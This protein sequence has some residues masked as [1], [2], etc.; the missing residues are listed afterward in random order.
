[1][2]NQLNKSI[3]ILLLAILFFS[4]ISFAQAPNFNW[5][6]RAGGTDN[7]YAAS[8]TSDASGNVYVT[9]YYANTTIT[10]GTITLTRTSNSSDGFLVKYNSSGVVQ[11]AI[12]MGSTF[13][14]I[15]YDVVTD[16]SGNIFVTGTFSSAT[17][18]FGSSTLTNSNPG[19]GYGDI[20][21]AKFDPSN[22]NALWAK[23]ATGVT[24]NKG[25][26]IS[27]S[28]DVD[29]S[30]NVFIT[31][32]FRGA[33]LDFEG[34]ATLYNANS[35]LPNFGQPDIFIAKYA[36]DGTFQW[37]QSAGGTSNDY[38]K[39]VTTDAAG[40]AII[41]G[42][43]NSTDL[44]FDGGFSSISTAGIDDIFVAKYDG[45][46]GNNIWANRYGGSGTDKGIGITTDGNS[47]IYVTGDFTSG[48]FAFGTTNLNLTGNYDLFIAKLN[49]SGTPQWAKSAGTFSGNTY[50]LDVATDPSN[51]VYMAAS[52]TGSSLTVGATTLNNMDNSG[53]FDNATVKYDAAGT[54]L[55]VKGAGGTKNDRVQSITVDATGR[56]SFAGAFDGL[57]SIF[58]TDTLT[59]NTV[60]FDDVFVAQLG[61]NVATCTAPNGTVAFGTFSGVTSS[62]TTTN[63]TYTNGGN[64]A[65]GYV[66]LRNTTNTAP[67]A[68][69]S[70]TAVPTAGNSVTW[71]GT[72]TV[73]NSTT[74]LGSSVPFSSTGLSASTTYYYWVVAYQNTNGPCWF[75][76]AT[77]ANNSQ[78]TSAVTGATALNFDGVDDVVTI[79][80][81]TTFNMSSGT[82]EA[83]FK[84]SNAGSSFRAIV[85]KEFYYGIFLLDNKIYVHNWSG[86][87]SFTSAG[88]YNDNN[89]H[90]VAFVFQNGVTNGSKVF[91][92]GVAQTAFTYNA[93]SGTTTLSIG[94]SPNN[95]QNFN[96]TI[97]EVRI[98][99]TALCDGDIINQRNCQLG[100]TLSSNLLAYYQ[101]NQGTDAG[102]NTAITTL[103][104]SKSTYPGTLSG[105]TLTGSTSNFLSG[106][107][108]PSGVTCTYA[109]L[110]TTASNTGA[111]CSGATISVS[112]SPSGGTPTYTYSW[113]SS[114]GGAW[115]AT[116]S[117]ATR[118][119][120]TTAMSGAYN[121][122]VTDAS[123]CTATASTSV[124]VN[125]NPTASIGVTETSG[126]TNNDGTI[127]NGASATLTATGGGTY[128]W[129]TTATTAAITVN[130]GTTTPYTVT[131]TSSGCTATAS[132][133]ITV[134]ANPSVSIGVTETSGTTNNDGTICNG[135]SATLTAS[136]GGTYLWSTSA[137][138]AAITVNPGTTTPYT[139]TVTSS[140]C[141]ATAGSSITVNANPATPTITANETSGTAN[142]GVIC[143]GAGVTL[144]GPAGATTYAWSNS[145]GSSQTSS[146][147]SPSSNTTYSLAVS[148]ASGCIASNSYTVT[149]TN[150]PTFSFSTST[151]P[152]TCGA[153][154]GTIVLTGLSNSTTYSVTYSKN[155]TPQSAANFTSNGSGQLT[156]TGLGAGN[157][158]NIIVTLGGCSSSAYSGPVVLSDP[159]APAAPTVGSN[160]PVCAGSTINLTATGAGTSF[161]WTGPNTYTSTTQNPTRP[162]STTAMS[163][164]YCATQTLAGCTSAPACVTVTVNAN[165]TASIGVT[166]TSGTANND[167][168]ICNGAS[169]TLTASGGG[170]Y[171]WS[172][173]ATTAAITVNPG[174]TTPYTV[175]VTSS[176]CTATASS[177][178]TVNANPSVSIGVT[179]TSGTTNNDGTICN[180]ASATLTASGGGTYLWSTSATTAA[181]TVNPGTT[182]PYTVTVTSSGCTATAGSSITVN[183]NPSVSIGVTETSGTANNDGTIC[184]GASATLTATG[185]GT[186]LWSTSATTAAI[187][188]NPGTTTPYT[189][190]VTSSGCTA[191]AGS[192]ITVNA[193][194]T[195]PIIG[196]ITQPTCPV[197]TGSVTLNGLPASGSWTVTNQYGAT[198]T[199]S[200][201]NTADFTNLFGGYSYTFTV[202]TSGCTSPSSANAVVNL[203][204]AQPS[205]P[206]IGN[207]THPT[208]ALSTG[209]VELSGLPAAAWTV[210][211]TGGATL[212]GSTAI[213]TFSGLAAGTYT[214]TVQD[215]NGCISPAS[216]PVTI[217]AQPTIP[218]PT[219]T[220]NPTTTALTC[221]TT[222]ID[223]TANGG[224]TYVWSTNATTATISATA[225]GTYTVTATSSNGCT[226][227]ASETITSNTLSAAITGNTGICAGSSTTLSTAQV[228]GYTYNWQNPAIPTGWV[229]VGTPGFSADQASHQ[230]LAID[231][232]GTPYVAY[233]DAANNDKTTVMKFDGTA[234]VTVGNAG[235]SADEASYQSLTIYNNIPYVAYRDYGNN[236]K[237]TVMKFNGTAWVTVGNAGFSAGAASYQSLAIDNTGTP[238]VAYQDMTANYKTTVMKF[239][240]TA[241]VNVG[242]AAFSSPYSDYQSLAIYNGTP[243]V[244]YLNGLQSKT[245]VLKFDGTAWINVGNVDVSLG[246]ADNQSLAIDNTGTP[247]VAYKDWA[248]SNKTT[249][250]KFDGTAWV[251]VGN[252]GFSQGQAF[253]Q[254]LAIDNTGTPY[255]VYKDAAN[256]AKTTVMKFNGTAWVNVGNAGFSAGYSDY[257]SLSIDNTGTLYV[258]YKDGGNGDK[259]TVLKFNTAL[260][261]TNTLVVNTPGTY[262]LT[263][264]DASG[265]TATANAT[266]TQ[267]ANTLSVTASTTLVSTNG[268]SNGAIDLTVNDGTPAYNYIWSPGIATTQDIAN[269]TAGVYNVTVTDAQGCSAT[270]SYPVNTFN[271][272][273]TAAITSVTHVSCNGG[274]NGNATVTATGGTGNYTY[275]WNNGYDGS[276][277]NKTF[278]GNNKLVSSGFYIV[279]V[280]DGN[281]EATASVTINEPPLLDF[282]TTQV[283]ACGA[284]T[285]SI[286]VNATGGTSP[287]QYASDGATFT[288]QNNPYTFSGLT[289]GTYNVMVKDA[290]G[291]TTEKQV[292]VGVVTT[293]VVP[294]N[295]TTA[296]GNDGSITLTVEGGTAPYTY[297]WGDGPTTQNRTDLTAGSYTVTI[298]DAGGCSIIETIFITQPVSTCPAGNTLYVDQSVTTSGNGET[299]ATAYKELSE[300]L[301]KAAACP[302]I[303][304]I[305]VA[306]GTYKPLHK[307][308]LSNGNTITTPDPRDATF[309]ILTNLAVYG[310]HPTGG[311]TRDIAAN[312]TTLSG[313]I[314]NN[315]N[316][317]HVVLITNGTFS[318]QVTI[319]G[320]TITDGKAD[321]GGKIEVSVFN[322][323][324]FSVDQHS[325]G[326]IYTCSGITTISN[327]NITGNTSGSDGGGIYTFI[328]D[329]TISNNII[330]GNSANGGDGGG[331]KCFNSN[332]T[333]SNNTVSG[334][335]AGIDGGGIKCFNSNSTI[336]N[337][338]V[339]GN[340]AVIDGG[341]IETTN[342]SNTLSNNTLSRNEAE[343][344]GG[345]CTDYGNNTLSNNTL[346]RNTAGTD[347]GGI[348]TNGGKNTI[349]NNILWNNNAAGSSSIAEA[350]YGRGNNTT[351]TF[352]NNLLQLQQ[353]E[354]T[355]AN[356]NDLGSGATGNLFAVDPKFVN[357]NDPNVDAGL[358][359]QAGS[360][361]INAGI[362][363][364]GIPA[365]D[366]LG[367]AR[368]GATDIGAYEFTDPCNAPVLYVD[369]TVTTSGNGDSWATA[370]K[371]LSDALKKAHECPNVTQILV[372]KGTY[373]PAF[374]PFENGEE[375]TANT[376]DRDKTFHLRGNLAVYGGYDATTGTR[377]I[378]ANPTILSGDIGTDNNNT[379]NTYHVVLIANANAADI[380]TLD[381]FTISGGNGNGGVTASLTINGQSVNKGYGGGIYT[382]SG[383]NIISNNTISANTVNKKGGGI[384]T[385]SGTNTISNNTFSNNTASN[386]FAPNGGGIYTSGGT[387]TISNNTINGNTASANGGGIYT[388]NGTVT[389][390]NNTISGNTAG[391]KG[392]GISG[393]GTISNNTITGNTANYGGGI[394][395]VGTI[396]N[397]TITG[398]TAQ[399]YGGGI[400][401]SGDNTINN[402]IFWNNKAGNDA[403]AYSA[404]YYTEF[405]PGTGDVR[406]NNTFKNNLLQLPSNKYTSWQMGLISLLGSGSSGNIF[407]Q[408]PQFE[409]ASDIDGPD[410]KHRTD[411]DGLRL[412]AESPCIN[413]GI[414]DNAPEK[415]IL[416]STRRGNPEMGAY[417]YTK[418]DYP[419]FTVR[420]TSASS[421]HE[422][423]AQLQYSESITLTAEVSG[424]GGTAPVSYLWSAEYVVLG[425]PTSEET[426][427]RFG[428]NTVAD[429]VKLSVSQLGCTA[430][431]EYKVDVYLTI[432][433]SLSP[434]G[435]G[436]NDVLTATGTYHDMTNA[437]WKIR[438]TSTNQL[439]KTGTGPLNWDG[440]TDGGENCPAG[441]YAVT[442]YINGKEE[443]FNG[444]KR[445]Q[446]ERVVT[447][448]R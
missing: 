251:N 376:T 203:P 120:S 99:N 390:I 12:N 347:G 419:E 54:I 98:W 367:K 6:N 350:D 292:V 362:T 195:A 122:T 320:F 382:Y 399:T 1:M 222:S 262:N 92:D 226:A 36:A 147:F 361:A 417:E 121:V 239:N 21:L 234:W 23:Q 131:V 52:Y 208:C 365:T 138:T 33:T 431:T 254:K 173:S 233:K 75:T 410:N 359:L 8:I 67:T 281:C 115:T 324:S 279:T 217:N 246:G 221:T 29:A 97:D 136:G 123:S 63:V 130:P 43:S 86:G 445:N 106:G 224:S 259:T 280:S 300:A 352:T 357:A 368:V 383:T 244:T 204:P 418:C 355:G 167:G 330:S 165:P 344:G 59:N 158:T 62:A 408:D 242:N 438:S 46:T 433:P 90:H 168:T 264:T 214:F 85:V 170:T 134:N 381:G 45:A 356:E 144:T 137:T 139:V 284:T 388:D 3:F 291:C 389:I 223:L 140:G 148:N 194:P 84:T 80:N 322:Q 306:A 375:I 157:Y 240:G 57:K 124:T 318:E 285:G 64:A 313:D 341:G 175:T 113:A 186:Y 377:D 177:S 444:E 166:E 335:L 109:P 329:N 183:A 17:H 193:N 252:A 287:Y 351:N 436:T 65:S 212:T 66:L 128:L 7:D 339:S 446:Y 432:N 343:H 282:T 236:S 337:N 143:N 159:S 400:K 9:G 286:T 310:G 403:N 146:S 112:A 274:V 298:T 180:G 342:G 206:T 272:N 198:I 295:V 328:G 319:D 372:A 126:T 237:T 56:V 297:A 448:I 174:T 360:P 270:G 25:S 215:Q 301:Q 135:A 28:V 232:N 230:S 213:A 416:D 207:I 31:G 305:N 404:D 164:S 294:A 11:W 42:Y 346:S 321:G 398:N 311:G 393:V 296:G 289:A 209:S 440:N 392:G 374:K 5:A 332:S 447:L 379:D 429:I 218:A 225:A 199:G 26:E 249:V 371:E 104:D 409:D 87:A 184:N 60:N 100:G 15:P 260:S 72:Y 190:T 323:S 161:N 191:T 402:N 425:S 405:S 32:I 247:Y 421:C 278:L 423:H 345:I 308:Y 156:I 366:K 309:H 385:E 38:G 336:S 312:L 430:N 258:A 437:L 316:A 266:V 326:G 231:N 293:S 188:V 315:G 162:N 443:R 406:P 263:V 111:Y 241:W 160:S 384:Y 47:N 149:V 116:G 256:G 269:L 428:D 83:W 202:T 250:R 314:G 181:I 197:P 35:T 119:S 257:Q 216:A 71:G 178:I 243:Y 288:A 397:N 227:S 412:N 16:A 354:Y 51:N 153:T 338:T 176:G 152:A 192:S 70:G 141:T 20:F 132:S 18:T 53:T 82:L 117:P 68:P 179:E 74:T 283:N 415:D 24:G 48:T 369:Q 235:F 205:A 55:W 185:G 151:N 77:Q 101:F 125:A 163:G 439:V 275:V 353:T 238:Y 189:V 268:G 273:L 427:C 219:I 114:A 78:A 210:T 349:S 413:T 150:G 299:W 411:D 363:G 40:N 2:L 248:S 441:E 391:G 414:K 10:F 229:N 93:S 276:S 386:F 94:N 4:Q 145:G 200:N 79:S 334:N 110:T 108:T 333:I 331:I 424:Y 317:Y 401:T 373:K 261:N 50:G 39:S 327:N 267:F 127:C 290:N 118:A 271:C 255:V 201:T 69:A 61:A 307:P 422:S 58:D 171:L 303:T 27:N 172:T 182:T 96:G 142:D 364:S 105:F 30:G 396:S 228:A 102:N 253:N 426:S 245:T 91:I 304:T 49:S 277:L 88:T 187:T 41:T 76:P 34:Q 107:S 14:T 154:N 95:P 103:T 394:S 380:D 44:S 378:A 169:A 435:D 196:T 442:L 387:N 340:L 370:I 434:N 420:A 395:G 325:G 265:C 37:A 133:S 211:A 13:S 358:Q 220:N 19:G 129:S 348:Y 89:W 73:V 302:N 81:S 22:G 155:G 407:A